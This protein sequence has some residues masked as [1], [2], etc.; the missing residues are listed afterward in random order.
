[1]I[2]V[3][4]RLGIGLAL[5]V[6]A[7]V[8]PATAQQPSSGAPAGRIAF[9]NARA[10]LQGMPGYAKAE[11]TY[12]KEVQLAT[13][14]GQRLQAAFDSVLATYDQSK[15][16]MTPSARTSREK[17]LSTQNDSL[18]AKLQLLQERVGSKERDLLAPMQNRLSAVIDGVRAELNYSV[19]IDL[20][21]PGAANVFVSF[22]K[23]LDITIL[24]ARRLS[25]SN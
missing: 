19:V 22:D 3:V 13:A 4:R 6:L 8:S 5:S 12:T 10:L 21:A 16:M 15:A 14:E 1:M 18:Q 2:V 24:V 23:A 11:S 17:V 9:I 25:Q 20:G 7:G